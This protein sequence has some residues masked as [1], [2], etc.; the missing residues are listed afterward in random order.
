MCYVL[1]VEILETVRHLPEP[2]LRLGLGDHPVAFDEVQKVAVVRVSGGVV[3]FIVIRLDDAVYC[4]CDG[5]P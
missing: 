5:L 4:C 1:V 2:H 3:A